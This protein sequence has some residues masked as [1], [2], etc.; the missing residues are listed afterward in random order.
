MA[1]PRRSLDEYVKDRIDQLYSLGGVVRGVVVNKLPNAIS[2]HA[3]VTFGEFND[4]LL[5]VYEHVVLEDGV[6]HRRKYGYQC[7]YEDSFLFRY[8]RDPVQHPEMAEH[9]HIGEGRRIAADRVTLHDVVDEFW[10]TVAERD[11]VA[12]SELED[13]E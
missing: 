4:G 11:E 9:K 5:G 8:D 13:D 6:P 3:Q 12:R 1:G 10:P 2:I 7:Q